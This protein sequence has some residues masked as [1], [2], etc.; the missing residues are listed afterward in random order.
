MMNDETKAYKR[1]IHIIRMAGTLGTDRFHIDD[2]YEDDEKVVTIDM[3]GM[4]IKE[5]QQT[6]QQAQFEDDNF[7]NILTPFL[8]D[9]QATND[10]MTVCQLKHAADQLYELYL[11]CKK[12]FVHLEVSAINSN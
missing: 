12:Q 7:M 6:N 3:N 8:Q 1:F 9:L 11:K 2:G 4:C 10:N 5:V